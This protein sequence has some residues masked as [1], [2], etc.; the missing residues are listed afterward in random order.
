MALG[1]S[2][3]SV[4]GLVV[5]HATALVGAGLVIGVAAAWYLSAAVQSFLFR[6]EPTDPRSFAAAI[7]ALG[8]AA[9]VATVVPARRAATVDPLT[10][11]R[12]P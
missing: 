4:I 12:T 9:I 3:R 6:I 10:S 11:L 1:A 8:L 5:R 7:A 2:R